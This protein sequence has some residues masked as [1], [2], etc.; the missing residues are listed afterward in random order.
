[1][2]YINIQYDDAQSFKVEQKVRWYTGKKW[3]IHIT[4]LATGQELKRWKSFLGCQGNAWKTW[5]RDGR[6]GMHEGVR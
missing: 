6:Q 5:P 1:M 3:L 4:E 2:K